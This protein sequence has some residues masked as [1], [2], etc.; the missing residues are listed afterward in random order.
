MEAKLN[1]MGKELDLN[2]LNLT[3]GLGMESGSPKQIDVGSYQF[4]KIEKNLR[5]RE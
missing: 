2:D 5:E 1:G 3:I 4:M